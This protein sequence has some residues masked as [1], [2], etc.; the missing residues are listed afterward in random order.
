MYQ[1]EK[2]GSQQLNLTLSG[3]VDQPQM[4]ALL[5]ELLS[6]SERMEHGRMLY[7]ISNFEWPSWGAVWAEM[8]LLPKLFGLIRRFDRIALV[9]DQAWLRKAGSLE[10]RLIPGLTIRNFLPGN[11]REAEDWLGSD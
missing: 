6:K 2:V 3:K 9:A 10:G 7:R 8:K 5:G 4:D 11:E 1:L